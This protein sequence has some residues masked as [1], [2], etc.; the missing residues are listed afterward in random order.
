MDSK[1]TFD[2]INKWFAIVVTPARAANTNLA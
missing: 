2:L 1:T